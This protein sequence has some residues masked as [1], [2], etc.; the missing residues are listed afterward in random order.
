MFVEGSCFWEPD[1]QEFSMFS[2]DKF[3]LFCFCLDTRGIF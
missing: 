1:S 3:I 2:V